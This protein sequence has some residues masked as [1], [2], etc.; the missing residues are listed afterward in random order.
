LRGVRRISQSEHCTRCD[1][2]L[3]YSHRAGDAG[4]QVGVLIA[5]V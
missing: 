1:N 3:F 2:A 5:P 4:R